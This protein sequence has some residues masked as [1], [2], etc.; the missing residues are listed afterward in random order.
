MTT[1]EG[2]TAGE[3]RLREALRVLGS[4][5]RGRPSSAGPLEGAV[6]A[7][8]RELRRAVERL[9]HLVFGRVFLAMDGRLSV[10]DIK[11]L[12]MTVG[13]DWEDLPGLARRTKLREL[14]IFCHQ[15]DRV[16]E[17]LEA[18]HELRPNVRL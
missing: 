14:I 1:G 10:D 5:Y 13:V 17:L 4:A 15:Q 11:G 6:L 9:E 2:L 8:L 12:C 16:G 7:E 3:D 18:F